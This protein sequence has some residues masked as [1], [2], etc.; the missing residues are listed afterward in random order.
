VYVS[1]TVHTHTNC[2]N[3]RLKHSIWTP[4]QN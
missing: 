1:L 2:K 3:C 4:W